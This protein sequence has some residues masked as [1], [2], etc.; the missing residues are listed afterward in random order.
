M[1]VVLIELVEVT[2]CRELRSA[3]QNDRVL[4]HVRD[5]YK[6]AVLDRHKC[7]RL[8]VEGDIDLVR[9]PGAFQVLSDRQWE[10]RRDIEAFITDRTCVE[11]SDE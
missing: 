5:D 6:L 10:R 1:V 11:P 2:L 9:G 3:W 4:V 7:S 8:V